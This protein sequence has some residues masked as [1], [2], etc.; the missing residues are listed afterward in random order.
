MRDI[1]RK[2][3]AHLRTAMIMKHCVRLCVALVLSLFGSSAFAKTSIVIR[4]FEGARGDQ[5]RAWVVKLLDND[6]D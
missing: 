6:A 4:N 3:A 1:T 5:A 2:A